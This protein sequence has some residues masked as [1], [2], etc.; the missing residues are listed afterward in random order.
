MVLGHGR[1]LLQG[2]I[3]ELEKPHQHEFEVR[4]KGDPAAFAGRLG[5]LGIP[6]EPVDDHVMVR[7]P[8]G[9]ASRAIWEAARDAGE[10]VR[11]FRPRRST[12]EEVFLE[13]VRG[14][15]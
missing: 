9:R 7:L 8:D 11:G 14:D 6:A 3:T 4:V 10:Q 2:R 12:L 5:A 15:R 13:A 1:L